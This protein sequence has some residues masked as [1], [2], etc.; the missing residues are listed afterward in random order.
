MY[1]CIRT[2]STLTLFLLT[3]IAG[4]VLEPWID[5][6]GAIV[7][8]WDRSTTAIGRLHGGKRGGNWRW[9]RQ[10]GNRGWHWGRQLQRGNRVLKLLR[11][12]HGV[13]FVHLVVCYLNDRYK[14]EL[15]CIAKQKSFRAFELLEIS[16]SE[17]YFKGME[18]VVSKKPSPW[19]AMTVFPH[20][21]LPRPHNADDRRK[22]SISFGRW[23]PDCLLWEC[24]EMM[25]MLMAI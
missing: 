15:K 4:S 25:Y 9:Q 24:W 3:F 11:W 22:A 6:E 7:A 17:R 8:L 5:V 13:F 21:R 16:L 20:W 18:L 2:Y 12:F 1:I 10:S 19:Q 14:W 23:R